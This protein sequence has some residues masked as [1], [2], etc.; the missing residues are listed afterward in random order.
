[1]PELS[2]ESFTPGFDVGKISHCLLL[3]FDHLPSKL[4]PY[5]LFVWN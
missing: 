3:C 5:P 1:M 4:L 2:F